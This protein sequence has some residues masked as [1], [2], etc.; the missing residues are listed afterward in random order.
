MICNPSF[1]LARK[2][3]PNHQDYT[4]ICCGWNGEMSQ[5][6]LHLK[7]SPLCSR[8]CKFI[9]Q[10]EQKISIRE[11]PKLLK[12]ARS[13]RMEEIESEDDESVE[14]QSEP[15]EEG[16]D[17]DVNSTTSGVQTSDDRRIVD[18]IMALIR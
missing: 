13:Y 17:V 5:L 14:I 15:T 3:F 12:R 7:D 1:V 16:D 9:Q 8:Y 4:E 6:E 10:L 11:E 2:H 18:S